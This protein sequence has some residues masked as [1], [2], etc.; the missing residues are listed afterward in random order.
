MVLISSDLPGLEESFS[1][2]I[3][4]LTFHFFHLDGS[5]VQ[6][7]RRLY[8]ALFTVLRTPNVLKSPMRIVSITIS[9]QK[10]FNLDFNLFLFSLPDPG[11]PRFYTQHPLLFAF[12]PMVRMTNIPHNSSVRQ[13]FNEAFRLIEPRRGTFYV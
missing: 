13:I 9:L 2:P 7:I 12:V 3:H 6:V 4:D 11:I 10:A 8:Y 5:K 1:F